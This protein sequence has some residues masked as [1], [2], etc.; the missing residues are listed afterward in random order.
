MRRYL[1]DIIT[2]SR[3]LV[4]L[5][6]LPCATFGIAFWCLYAW[7]G[8]SDMLDGPIARKTGSASRSGAIL[9]SLAD[10]LFVVVCFVKI[11]PF[12]SIP[13]WLW[14]WVAVIALIKI[15]NIVVGFAKFRKLVMPH[16]VA[17]KLTGALL[18]LLPVAIQFMPHVVPVAVVCAVAMGSAVQEESF[19]NS[20]T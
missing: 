3:M 11:V 2:V 9:D 18:F 12:V 16:T 6:L 15:A 17:N 14:L 20:V 1:A 7:C 10:L 19:V 4:S 13:V 8:L 5:A